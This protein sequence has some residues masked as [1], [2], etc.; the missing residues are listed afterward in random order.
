[1]SRLLICSTI[2]DLATALK[3]ESEWIGM[4]PRGTDRIQVVKTP[5]NLK[6]V[7]F[8][9]RSGAIVDSIGVIYQQRRFG[10]SVSVRHYG[11]I[12]HSNAKGRRRRHFVVCKEGLV[13]LGSRGRLEQWF[14]D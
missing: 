14:S 11:T 3:K 12:G 4:H 10:A 1:M 9:G 13:S 2:E 7:G 6:I 8:H 5:Q